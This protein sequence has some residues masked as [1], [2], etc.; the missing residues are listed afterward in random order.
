MVHVILVVTIAA[1]GTPKM[2]S[3]TPRAAAIHGA[4]SRK[5]TKEMQ[6]AEGVKF[7]QGESR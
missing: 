1:P 6:P 5:E 3:D 4:F 2:A 7:R